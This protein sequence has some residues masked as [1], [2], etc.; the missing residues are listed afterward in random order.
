MDGGEQVRNVTLCTCSLPPPPIQLGGGLL[1]L[2]NRQDLKYAF[3]GGDDFVQ[4]RN[5]FVK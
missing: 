2:V 1:L 3:T 4:G 5:I